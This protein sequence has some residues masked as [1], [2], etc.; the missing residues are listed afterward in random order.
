M[1]RES[2]SMPMAKRLALFLIGTA[3]AVTI[4]VELFTLQGDRANTIFKFYIQAWVILSVVGG[5][6]L[7]WLLAALPS[8]SSTWR[9][10]WTAG[11]ALLVGGAALYTVTATSAKVSDRFP[12][13]ATSDQGA[14]CAP[15][16]GMVLP[17][18][19]GLPPEQQ[20]HS[21]YG[22]DYMTWSAYCDHGYFL[23]LAYDYHV[24]RYLHDNVHGSPVIAEAQSFELYRRCSTCSGSTGG[25]GQ[26]TGPRR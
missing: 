17:Y 3:L 8:W 18:S 12:S 20:P 10:G 25:T 2:N 13:Y 4:F 6:A 11:L 23:P 16:P 9:T 14:G 21:L 22:L 19:Q 15:L 5:A 1:L 7:A 26:T 24:I